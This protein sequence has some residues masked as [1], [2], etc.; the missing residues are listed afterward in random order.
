VLA[1]GNASRASAQAWAFL[2][3]LSETQLDFGLAPQGKGLIQRPRTSSDIAKFK[4]TGSVPA[5]GTGQRVV[6]LTFYR[7]TNLAGPA[8]GQVPFSM[9]GAYNAIA[10]DAVSATTFSGTS[11]DIPLRILEGYTNGVGVFS[12]YVYIFGN[13]T[14]SM[15]PVGMYTA[16]ITVTAEP[17][18]Q[19]GGTGTEG[20]EVGW[21]PSVWYN[22]GDWAEYN[23]NGWR[24]LWWNAG[25]I[26]GS[27]GAT[28]PW[29]AMGPCNGPIEGTGCDAFAWSVTRVYQAGAW[30]TYNGKAWRALFYTR[31]NI[32]GAA[33][34]S[35]PW[36][37]VGPCDG[38][39]WN[40]TG[41][42]ALTW[43]VSRRYNAGDEA[44]YNG[45]LWRALFFSRGSVPGLSTAWQLVKSCGITLADPLAPWGRPDGLI[46]LPCQ[47]RG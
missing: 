40:G 37:E 12:A 33:G 21:D 24:S 44:T 13:V 19:T 2:E 7:P 38:S 16:N 9:S 26:P 27:G 18:T 35:G 15:V 41:C 22:T 42:A 14:V 32:P 36:E 23:G 20:C 39:P 17:T 3:V 30:A 47:S 43:A 29:E 1:L 46:F 28:D 11:V 6:T 25:N 34:A 5:A 4:I 10:D 45:N 31:G 8:S